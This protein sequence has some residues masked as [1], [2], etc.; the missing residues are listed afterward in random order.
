MT[1]WKMLCAELAENLAAIAPLAY[2]IASNDEEEV[3]AAYYLNDLVKRAFEAL[4]DAS[5]S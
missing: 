1:D 2:N 4:E 5:P 3:E